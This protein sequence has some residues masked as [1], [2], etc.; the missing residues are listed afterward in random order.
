MDEL[1]VTMGQKVA[2]KLGLLREWVIWSVTS[3][4]AAII[5]PTLGSLDLV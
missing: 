2:L 3:L 4:E 1:T 5:A